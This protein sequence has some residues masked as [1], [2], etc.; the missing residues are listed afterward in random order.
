[1]AAGQV[2]KQKKSK[3]LMA[4]VF[5]LMERGRMPGFSRV[6]G[7]KKTEKLLGVSARKGFF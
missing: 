1:M 6:Y 3:P 2:E 4:S 7:G 5:Y